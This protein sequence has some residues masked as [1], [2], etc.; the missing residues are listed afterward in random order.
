MFK[1]LR[2]HFLLINITIISFVMITALAVIYS[3]TYKKVQSEIEEKLRPLEVMNQ[4]VTTN[5]PIEDSKNIK[6]QNAQV[7][8]NRSLSFVSRVDKT[9]KMISVD[10]YLNLSNQIYQKLSILAWENKEKYAIIDAYGKKWAYSKIP[11]ISNQ[12]NTFHDGNVVS[13]K[14]EENKGEGSSIAFLDVTSSY[15]MLQELLTTLIIVG[16]GMVVAIF[17]MS[18]YFAN[19]A[20]QP[21]EESWE[22][23][24]QFIAHASHELKTPLAIISANTDAILVSRENTIEQSKKWFD[25]IREEIASMSKL[26]NGLLYLAK[27]EDTTI[28]TAYRTFNFSN[29][30]NNVI[31]SME[32]VAFENQVHLRHQIEPNI[33]MKGDPDQIKQLL[34]ILLDNAI[35]YTNKNGHISISVCSNFR[36]VIYSIR[37]TGQGIK[38]EE[39]T[40]IF[41]RFY[42]TDASRVNA[43]GYGLGL[44]VAK[45]IIDRH[46]GKIAVES[47]ENKHTTFTFKFRII[48][49]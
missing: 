35:K 34:I 18:L 39:L 9:G 3:I 40:K 16:I 26:I 29:M 22:K 4:M 36:Q 33:K 25:H 45:A 14:V 20:I 46:Q 32:A 5:G 17:C 48:H 8:V 15:Q 37:N 42:R 23:Q 38:K 44:A 6:F 21:I 28:R 30:V 13:S 19:R 47:V 41:D 12:V 11:L 27:T 1:K 43:N 7:L 10:S 2:N 49:E 31:L 24:K